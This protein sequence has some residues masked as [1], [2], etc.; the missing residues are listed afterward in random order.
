[1]IVVS[2]DVLAVLANKKKK[3][4]QTQIPRATKRAAGQEPTQ[5]GFFQPIDEP[6]G[7][8]MESS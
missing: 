8:A 5:T 4:V 6:A 3:K 1:M 7:F 2:L